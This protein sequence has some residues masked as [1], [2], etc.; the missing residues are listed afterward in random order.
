M[1]GIADDV[2]RLRLVLPRPV[3]ARN[4]IML[5]LLEDRHIVVVGAQ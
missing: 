5:G 3:D 4:E 2:A 1:V